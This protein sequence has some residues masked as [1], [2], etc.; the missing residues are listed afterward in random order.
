MARPTA[1]AA[2]PDTRGET[3]NVPT[4]PSAGIASAACSFSS[5]AD[6]SY[7][8]PRHDRRDAEGDQQTRA[9]RTNRWARRG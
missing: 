4:T 1:G 7:I 6:R 8:D 3:E 5:S 2:R 9:R